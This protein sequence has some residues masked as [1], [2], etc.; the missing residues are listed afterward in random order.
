M[1]GWRGRA[2]KVSTGGGSGLSC[3]RCPGKLAWA[4]RCST[5]WNL[6]A[7]K[8]GRGVKTGSPGLGSTRG[9]AGSERRGLG[10]MRRG[11]GCV[12]AGVGGGRGGGGG[13]VCRGSTSPL[14]S[15]GAGEGLGRAKE[16]TPGPRISRG[17]GPETGGGQDLA[18]PG[19]G[20]LWSL[21]RPFGQEG[22]GGEC[23]KSRIRLY[24]AGNPGRGRIWVPDGLG[25][26]RAEQGS[27][28]RGRDRPLGAKACGYEATS[29]R[30][31]GRPIDRKSV[32]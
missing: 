11:G 28:R 27:A 24:R 9:A 26:P 15:S 6:E 23:W 32:V 17:P 18:R 29:I 31:L 21:R 25:Y 14:A 2:V 12:G 8:A 16:R 5:G 1:G 22:A 30:R 20:A 7:R 4:G 13:A 19:A 10:W 3:R